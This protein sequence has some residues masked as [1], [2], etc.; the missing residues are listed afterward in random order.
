MGYYTDIKA[1]VQEVIRPN[2]VGA[3][4]ASDHQK[5]L[6][7]F[8]D[9]VESNDND[10]RKNVAI[11]REKLTELESKVGGYETNEEFARAYTDAEGKF[12][13]GIRHDGSIEFAKGIPTPILKK[14]QEVHQELKDVE[15]DVQTL[16]DTYHYVSDEEWACAIVDAEGYIL[17]GIKVDGSYYIANSDLY[18][19]QSSEEWLKAVVDGAGH[20]LFGIKSDGVCYIPKGISEDAKKGLLDLTSRIN[21]LEKSV[22]IE[23][24]PEMIA[25][26][27][28]ADGRIL[29]WV[30][31]D[32]KKHYAKQDL[33]ERIEDT[34]ERTHIILDAND[35]IVAFRDKNGA[36]H[37]KEF[38]CEVFKPKSLELPSSSIEQVIKEV[39]DRGVLG[40]YDLRL[41]QLR[42]TSKDL[43]VVGNNII[44]LTALKNEVDCHYQFISQ[45]MKF[46]DDGNIAYQGTSSIN[47]TKKGFSVNFANKHRF[48]EW[49]EMDEYHCKGYWGDWMHFRDLA[50]N[51][52]LEWLYMSR[53][54]ANNRPFKAYNDFSA[55]DMAIV[56]ESGILC[57]VDGFPIELYINGVYWGIYS[58]NIKKERANYNLNKK[59]TN[60]IMV[61]AGT[62]TYYTPASFADGGEGWTHVEVRNPK[63]KKKDNGWEMKDV[64]GDKYDNDAPLELIDPSSEAWDANDESCIKTYAVKQSWQRFIDKA[65]RI[66]PQ[67]TL[68]ELSEF[69]NVGE[70]VD[71]MIFCQLVM[72]ADSWSKNHLYTTWDNVHWSPCLYDFDACLGVYRDPT[73][74]E[75]FGMSDPLTADERSGKGYKQYLSAWLPTL[76]DILMPLMKKRYA[77]LKES[78]AIAYERY[79]ALL[80]GWL[81][82]I[83]KN[84]FDDDE[85]RW[86]YPSLGADGMY[87]LTTETMLEWYKNR[88]TFMDSLY[89]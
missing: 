51:K 48:G 6:L 25:S 55:N 10:L 72:H 18:H 4:T 87:I 28:D 68:E 14:I 75:I 71:A 83:G 15:K 67:T 37:E 16:T 39:E 23:D 47:H 45:T 26:T 70:W 59:N 89:R 49:I 65:N 7:D 84:A 1:R 31:G 61:E 64:N 19:V 24:N 9:K 54:F 86:N 27:I 46:E 58:I 34:E 21:I 44:G 88:L 85:A 12:L 29:D 57:H 76:H 17:M 73:T 82:G 42:V 77:E 69:M 3:I 52:I 56:S 53:P 81:K 62:D 66:T 41:P 13:W 74:G 50:S 8:V 33:F 30:D 79:E 35:K 40:G 60:H 22:F 11:D 32:G 20:V 63:P 80:L 38:H 5:L 43:E 2:G 78:G 36:M